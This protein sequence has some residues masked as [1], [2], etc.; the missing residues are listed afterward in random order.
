MRLLLI[1][2]LLATAIEKKK[3]SRKKL[4]VLEYKPFFQPSRLLSTIHVLTYTIRGAREFHGLLAAFI[5]Q[6]RY[7]Q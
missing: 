6:R 7:Q 4:H 5:C 3:G 2:L 1:P